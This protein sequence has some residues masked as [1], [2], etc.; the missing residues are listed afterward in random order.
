MI[1]TLDYTVKPKK[2]LWIEELNMK[3]KVLSY[4]IE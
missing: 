3:L 2:K 4:L 1:K